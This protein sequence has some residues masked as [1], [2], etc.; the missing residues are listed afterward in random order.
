[1]SYNIHMGLIHS[2]IS[3][4]NGQKYDFGLPLQDRATLKQ[5][6]QVFS[7]AE[8]LIGLWG[9]EKDGQ[10]QALGWITFVPNCQDVS[11]VQA[12]EEL[13]KGNQSS[14]RRDEFLKSFLSVLA[15]VLISSWIGSI[16]AYL[17]KQQD[18]Q[19]K[20]GDSNGAELQPRLSVQTKSPLNK[21]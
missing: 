15:F 11:Y 9:F 5:R 21:I 12:K 6:S 13:A 8:Q 14:N 18:K 7:P 16:S 1:M 17:K 4:L 10:A 20:D 2:Q 3:L 19:M